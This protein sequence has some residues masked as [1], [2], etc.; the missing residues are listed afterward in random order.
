MKLNVP[1]IPTAMIAAIVGGSE[2]WPVVNQEAKGAREA[3]DALRGNR[4]GV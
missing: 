2:F 3:D 1:T 4:T